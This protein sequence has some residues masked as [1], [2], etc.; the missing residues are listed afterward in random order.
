MLRVILTSLSLISTAQALADERIQL[1]N[2]Y[3]EPAG[4][5]ERHG[6][7]YKF[8]NFYHEPVGSA[9]AIH[10]PTPETSDNTGVSSSADTG[11]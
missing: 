11:E 5:I 9:K 2:F 4:S 6:D 1:Y 10:T 3:H 8:F 7:T